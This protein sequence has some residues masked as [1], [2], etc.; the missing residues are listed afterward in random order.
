MLVEREFDAKEV[1][2]NSDGEVIKSLDKMSYSMLYNDKDI[3]EEE[4][5][6]IPYKFLHK[7]EI[8]ENVVVMPTNE[9]LKLREIIQSGCNLTPK[10]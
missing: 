4:I 9:W 6:K 10:D 3:S 1:L 7:E 8:P 5:L 2:R